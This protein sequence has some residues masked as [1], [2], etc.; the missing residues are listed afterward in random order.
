MLDDLQVFF[1][2]MS[3][4]REHACKSYCEA[5]GTGFH[6]FHCLYDSAFV[7]FFSNLVKLLCEEQTDY[8]ELG[9]SLTV[10]DWFCVHWKLSV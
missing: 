3:S 2:F 4:I 6:Q 8:V 5:S 10:N 1:H 9:A 7:E